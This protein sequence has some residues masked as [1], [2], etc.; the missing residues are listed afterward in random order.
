[1]LI[2]GF[3]MVEDIA[4]CITMDAKTSG[5]LLVLVGETTSAMGGSHLLMIDPEANCD[6]SLPRVSLTDG[7]KNARVV[8]EAIQQGLVTSAHDCSEGGVLVAAAEMAFGGGI[9]VELSLQEESLCFAETP[10]RYLL[11]VNISK[12]EQLK[13]LLGETPCE[14]IGTF[15]DTNM[16]TLGDASWKLEDLMQSWMTGMVI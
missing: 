4:T 5:N 8:F 9:G 1:M 12:V 14:V 10:S 11:E 7:P 16:L 6:N 15:N 13:L 2:S 3:G